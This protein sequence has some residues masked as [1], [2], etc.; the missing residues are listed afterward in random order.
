MTKEG[1]LEMWL[2]EKIVKSRSILEH[3]E[4]AHI[5]IDTVVANF[6]MFQANWVMT[7]WA[8]AN[9]AL[10]NWALANWAPANWTASTGIFWYNKLGP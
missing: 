9:W 7:N 8:T 4:V 5:C 1:H 10:A 3:F 6:E 2:H